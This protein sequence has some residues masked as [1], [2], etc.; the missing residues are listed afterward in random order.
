MIT[1]STNKKASYFPWIILSF[2]VLGSFS[3]VTIAQERRTST[4]SVSADRDQDGLSNKEEELY[5]TN[6]DQRD[7]D[8]SLI[9]I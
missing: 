6:P 3:F 8:L 2:L 4:L 9:H 5:G 1:K 7:T